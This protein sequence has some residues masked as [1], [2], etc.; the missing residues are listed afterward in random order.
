MNLNQEDRRFWVKF[1][2]KGSGAHIAQGRIFDI[3]TGAVM[4]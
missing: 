4:M 3:A 2:K 1:R